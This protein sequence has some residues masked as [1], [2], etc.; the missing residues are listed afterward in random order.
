[1]KNKILLVLVALFFCVTA[2][3]LAE[4]QDPVSEEQDQVLSPAQATISKS[5]GP[6]RISL[7][8]KGMDVVDVL[9]MLATRAGI[10]LVIGKNVTG[11]VTLFLKDV[12][13]WDAFEILLLANDLAYEK[14]GEIVNVITQ[15]DYELQYGERFQDKK[16]ARTMPLKYARAADLS[17]ALNQIKTNIG[18]VVVDEGS[19][20]LVLI[21]TP[22][23]LKEMEE[24]IKKTDLPIQTRV[25]SLGYAQ[26][27]KL[28]PKLQEAVT[29][30]VGSIKIDERTNKIAITDYPEKLDEIA[31]II[32]AFDEKT[33]Q[34]LI[35]AQIIEIYP[36]DQ[37]SMGVDWDYWLKK[38]VRLIGSMPA[39]TL[40]GIDTI[41]NKFSLGAAA[42]D[43]VVSREGQYKSIIDLLRVIGDTKIL[44]SPRII[45]LN[46]QE[47]KIMVGTKEAYI[48]STTSQ[49]GTGPNVTSQAVNFVD[50][51]IKLYVTPTV[52]RD[53]FVTMK[54]R[55]EISSAKSTKIESEG[56]KS[57]IPIVTTSEA[58]TTVTIKD[59][60]TIII[61]GLKKDQRSKE[62]RKIPI[63][64]DIPLL[65]YL[66]RSTSDE[67]LKDELVI[68][69][70]PH[71]ISGESS[72]TDFSEVEPVQGAVAKMEKGNIVIEKI[73]ASPQEKPLRGSE[74]EY[75]KL[76]ADKVRAIASSLRPK[77]EIGR[78][79]LAFTV[80]KYG[81]LIDEP[82]V[83]ESTN[84]ALSTIAV[85]A[86]KTAAP[87]SP[88]SHYLNKD[89]EQFIIS[90][91]YE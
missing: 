13:V 87:F 75:Y 52:N 66:F 78:V 1:M 15:R 90:L 60:V 19:N 29:K 68:L 17:R 45:V 9:K 54:I 85:K 83:L 82:A 72:F 27:D 77:G 43:A 62:V 44:S 69:L 22:E 26:A 47:A 6:N 67:S 10:N 40:T 32:N 50:V 89:R 11:R 48:T 20:T 88:F 33:P 61:G 91:S 25:F 14:K 79:T 5:S 59:G 80:S 74:S 37:F 28:Q 46:N 73:E 63:L 81:M 35:D 42:A 12:D 56:Q 7:D 36:K 53:G 58:E 51:G 24:F 84:S 2:H 76:V 55:P 4:E 70:T 3:V 30:G 65:G 41:P 86:I 39:P 64:G 49:S 16:Q 8:I 57:D 71:I 18:R 31:K 23:K 38:N 21:D 34:V